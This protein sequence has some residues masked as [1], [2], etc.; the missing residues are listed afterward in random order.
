MDGMN[1]IYATAEKLDA[2]SREQTGSTLDGL[3][4][5]Q[6]SA[7]RALCS[8]GTLHVVAARGLNELQA[9]KRCPHL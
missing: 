8:V 2:P 6:R 7:A 4:G 5:A 1:F 9:R 3:Q